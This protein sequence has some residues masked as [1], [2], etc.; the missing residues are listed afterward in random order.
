MA[1]STQNQALA[2]LLVLFQQVLDQTIGHL[3]LV[4]A[5]R[6]KRLPVVLTPEEAEAVLRCIT[7]ITELVCELLYGG[8][9]RLSEGLQLR[10]KDLDFGRGEIVVRDGEGGR[11]RVTMLP[12]VLYDPASV[13]LAGDGCAEG[14]PQSR[15][16][17]G[18]WQ[19]GDTAHVATLL[20]HS[21]RD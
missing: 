20:G 19:A 21:S 11:D 8:G 2:A 10:V 7:G 13:S 9:L 18:D 12:A 4:R 15:P 1:A 16:A 5:K 17:C 3:D 6:P 14:F